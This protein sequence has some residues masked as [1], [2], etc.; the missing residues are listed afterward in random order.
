VET[1]SAARAHASGIAELIVPVL[2]YSTAVLLYRTVIAADAAAVLA[3]ASDLL[4]LSYYLHYWQ[5]CQ[6]PHIWG[7]SQQPILADGLDTTMRQPSCQKG[8]ATGA[9]GGG[10]GEG[11][12]P[13]PP[14]SR[15]LN[16]C[17]RHP[18]RGLELLRNILENY[19]C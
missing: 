4:P 17:G 2:V 14:C 1:R 11:A 8:V 7:L 12:A 3:V 13:P 19:Y 15:D 16:G 18:P 5:Y 10:P 6:R 9:G